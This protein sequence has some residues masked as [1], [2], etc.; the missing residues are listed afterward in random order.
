MPLTPSTEVAT[1]R[2]LL[3][4]VGLPAA[5]RFLNSRTPH[6]FTGVY[7]YDGDMLRNIALAD[8]QNAAATIGSDVRLSDAYCDYMT[9][10][11]DSMEFS[12]VRSDG[13]YPPKP[14]NP[15]T[16]YCGVLIRDAAGRPFGTLC[17]YDPRPCQPRTSDVP[18]LR[19]LA[20]VIYDQIIGDPARS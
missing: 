15:V 17:H 16:A 11:V 7:R 2:Q 6:R 4:E 19:E 5:L 10:D 1:F 14:G 3:A 8:K 12:D 13:R 9:D 18:L 20:T